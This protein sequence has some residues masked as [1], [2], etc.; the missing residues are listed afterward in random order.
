MKKLTLGKI[1][2]ILI[3]GISFLLMVF[4]AKQTSQTTDEAVH[5]FAG[6]TYLKERDFRLDPE[7][8][9]LLKELGALPL[10]FQKDLHF[11]IDGLWQ[12]TGTFY[13]DSWQETRLLSEQFLYELGNNPG[14]LLFF[15]RLVF[16]FLTMILGMF[17]YHWSR[18]IY[19]DKAGLLAL[20]LTLFFPN[21]LAHGILVN[22]DLGLTLFSFGT[23][24]FFGKY[25]KH[26]N[27]Y[28]LI[29]SGLFLGLAL[30][31]K[32]TAMILIPI[33]IILAIIKIIQEKK[34]SMAK[35]IG[36]I[37][38]ISIISVLIIWASYGFNLHPA[39]KISGTLTSEINFWSNTQV[40]LSP[41][42]EQIFN[43]L[44]PVLF[45]DQYFKGLILIFRHALGGHGA[46][47]LG[48]TSN[49]GW[50]YYFPAAILFKTPIPIFILITLTIIG[51]KKI[52][53]KDI[54][55][56]YLLLVP[57]I[58]FLLFS[59]AS[60]ADLGIRHILPIFPFLFIF[61]S[62]SINLIDF[63]KY[64]WKTIGF[65]AL[66]LWY[67]LSAILSYPNYIAYFN[68]FVGGSKNG[69]KILTDSNLDWGQDIYRIKDY[70]V[71]MKITPSYIV[72][73]WDSDSA[74]EYYDINYPLLKPEN[75]GAKG[76]IIMSATYYNTE[77]YKWLHKYPYKQITPGVFY[78]EIK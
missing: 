71:N 3:F 33:L 15:S 56:E 10:L 73:P 43:Q 31:S 57:I 18:K 76:H 46:Y 64:N 36:G 63:K 27:W 8:P 74:L 75:T 38:L 22:T 6:Y 16:I 55:D 34:F 26:A 21:I 29:L 70:I 17:I 52:K 41:Y 28:D 66:I 19:G 60:K 72:Y 35:Y 25:L 77:A 53:S 58:I 61:I 59:M 50:W 78:I 32:Y 24:Y 65:S 14:K 42:F 12:K 5:L 47:L 40:T 45:P 62:K 37:F 23:I 20:F 9:P 51:W 30:A 39:P 68:E 49:T 54:F 67:L 4:A 13:Y 7:H 2:L 11:Q 44:R 69:Y 48:M 1:I